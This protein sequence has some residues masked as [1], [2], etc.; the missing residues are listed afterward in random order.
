LLEKLDFQVKIPDEEKVIGETDLTEERTRKREAV[1]D[2]G[3][4]C[5]HYPLISISPRLYERRLWKGVGCRRGGFAR[6]FKF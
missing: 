1:E 5:T 2:C 6:T 3:D 4:P